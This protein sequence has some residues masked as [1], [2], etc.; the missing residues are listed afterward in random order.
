MDIIMC[1]IFYTYFITNAKL[2]CF[3]LEEGVEMLFE[4]GLEVQLYRNYFRAIRVK[5]LSK[6]SSSTR[7]MLNL[8]MYHT[9]VEYPLQDLF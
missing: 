8:F 1:N 3:Q 2:Q 7:L 9:G 4:Q 6:S 5:S